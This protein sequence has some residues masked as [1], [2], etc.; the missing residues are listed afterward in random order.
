MSRPSTTASLGMILGHTMALPLP[1]G[2]I[3]FR[4][5]EREREWEHSNHCVKRRSISFSLSL[6]ECSKHSPHVTIVQNKETSNY[7]DVESLKPP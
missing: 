6:C 5:G 3:L 2:Q 4:P 1:D 7:S